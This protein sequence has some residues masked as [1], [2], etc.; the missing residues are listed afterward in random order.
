MR[1]AIRG[2]CLDVV[3]FLSA[4]DVQAELLAR[5]HECP[6]RRGVEVVPINLEISIHRCKLLKW[7]ACEFLVFRRGRQRLIVASIP[8]LLELGRK[9]RISSV[10]ARRGPVWPFSKA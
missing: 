5:E 9:L 10:A 7:M 6:H 2:K 8:L 1:S 4:I 3:A